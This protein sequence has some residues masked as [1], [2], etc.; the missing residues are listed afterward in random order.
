M[1]YSETLDFLFAQLPMYQ[2]VGPAAYK[3]DLGNTLA[4]CAA[5][6]IPQ[7][8]FKSIH[9]AGTNGKGSTSHMIA[10]VLQAN[11]Y[12]TGLYTSPHLLDFR[13]RI[14]V[15]GQMVTEEFVVDFVERIREQ[16]ETIKPS[17]FEITVA[18][19]F[20]WFRYREVDIAV[21]ETGLGGRLDSTNV[22][23]PELSVITN[24]GYDHMDMLG[25]S[26]IQIAGEKAGIIKAGVPVVIGEKQDEIHHVFVDRAANVG[27]KLVVADQRQESLLQTDLKGNYQRKN[28]QTTLK[29][30]EV[31]KTL[32]FR[33]ET[34]KVEKGLSNVVKNTGLLGRWQITSNRP[35]TICDTGHNAEAITY[36]VE[37]LKKQKYSHLRIVFGAVVG[38]DL[39]KVL[40]LL[41]RKATYYFCQPSIPRALN[42]TELTKLAETFQL[43]GKTYESV[44]DASKAAL[45]ESESDDLI[46]IGGSTFVVADYLQS[47]QI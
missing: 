31:L 40:K 24:I 29:A 20:D 27:C 35:L 7:H 44:S 6:G 22:L 8:S 42:A 4:L 36:I 38:K 34:E 9:V 32:G 43:M 45:T 26:L 3:K 16:L 39:N 15:D 18:M 28:L 10:S 11:G 41:P 37:Q 19:A 14:R 5:L 33:L 12:S 46:F 13:E 25:D 47:I 17:F 21:V 30:I 23:L 1:N 2:R